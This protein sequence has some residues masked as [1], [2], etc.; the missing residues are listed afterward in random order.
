LPDNVYLN[1]IVGNLISIKFENII[2]EFMLKGLHA[3]FKMMSE[4]LNQSWESQMANAWPPVSG[5]L[6][7]GPRL[8]FKLEIIFD[9]CVLNQVAITY[10]HVHV[11]NVNTD[12]LGAS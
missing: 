12:V 2:N 5:A 6:L 8:K 11:R 7:F 4:W 3:G 9:I 1:F 10:N